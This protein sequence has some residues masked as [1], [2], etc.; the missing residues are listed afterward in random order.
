[1]VYL[2]HFS[3]PIGSAN[4]H[5]KAQHY[6]GWTP[7][8]NL[9]ERLEAHYTGRGAHIMRAVSQAGIEWE[10]VRT[11]RGGRTKERALKNHK[12]AADFCPYCRR[13]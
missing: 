9:A 4:A 13:K 1:M 3:R 6:I 8:H 12:K 5:G 10:L 11:W 7:D 2:I